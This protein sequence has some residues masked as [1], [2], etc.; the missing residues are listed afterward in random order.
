MRIIFTLACLIAFT[1]GTPVGQPSADYQAGEVLLH[2]QFEK[3]L[4]TGF[5]QVSGQWQVTQGR[6]EQHTMGGTS[7]LLA[8]EPDW[9][10]YTAR[11][12]VRLPRGQVDAEAGLA[13]QERDPKNYLVFSLKREK[14][15]PF[16]VLRIEVDPGL[17]MV[18]DQAPL[19]VDLD[20]WHELRADV[21]GV[22]V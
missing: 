13:L 21:H 8:G 17:K 18:G 5:E 11:V 4:P 16:G 14:G 7:L 3:G 2:A 10:D 6:L 19:Q 9:N 12:K 15:G 20:Q 22:D 1:F